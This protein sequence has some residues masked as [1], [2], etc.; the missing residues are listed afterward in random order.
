MQDV[1][2]I[3]IGVASFCFLGWRVYKMLTRKPALN[4]KCGSCTGCA[5]K[6]DVKCTSIKERK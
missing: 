6:L 5:L 2:V 1:I 3:L 4:S